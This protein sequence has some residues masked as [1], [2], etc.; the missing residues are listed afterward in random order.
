MTLILCL[1]LG[2]A[3]A[4]QASAIFNAEE[5]F[6]ARD[7][8]QE[9]DL[10]KAAAYNVSDGQDIHITASGIYVLTGSAKNVTVYVEAGTEDK[11]QIVLDGVT[12][13]NTNFPVIYAKTADKVFVTVSADSSL[14]VTGS[15]ISDGSVNTDG[16]I[17]AKTDLVLNGTASLTVSS[18]YNGIVC[19]DDLK[20]TGGTYNIT[21]QSKAFEAN[22]SI[23]ISDGTLNL[24]AGTDGLH[25]ENAEDDTKGYI[26]VSGGTLTIN[27]GDDAIHAN[28]VVQI[29]GGSFSIRAGEGIEG[30]YIQV[31]GGSINI[32]SADDGINAAHKSSAYRATV[33]I[34]GG[35]ISVAMAGGDTDGID[36]NGDIIINGGSISVTGNSTFDYDGSAQYNGG[37]IIANGQQLS[38]IPNQMMG[39]GGRGGWGNMGGGS[40]NG[41]W[42]IRRR[43]RRLGRQRPIKGCYTIC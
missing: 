19:K 31:N 40:M 26:Y 3:P 43:P 22:D 4:A 16:V 20:I 23:R 2:F 32:Q 9:A 30:T 13:T 39:G 7:L 10:S 5:L 8:K 21:A 42:G 28:S 6:S 41:G 33:E 1:A 14:S 17:F 34:N 11:V 25:A 37:T 36:S 15:F 29:D 38:Y 24:I 35:E 27:A 18:T 12:V